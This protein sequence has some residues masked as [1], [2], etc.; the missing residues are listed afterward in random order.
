MP[1]VARSGPRELQ[2]RANDEI[3]DMAAPCQSDWQELTDWSSDR[4]SAANEEDWNRLLVV[5]GRIAASCLHPV[6]VLVG[7]PQFVESLTRFMLTHAQRRRRIASAALLGDAATRAIAQWAL[8]R[9][10]EL[11]PVQWLGTVEP[12]ADHLVGL[13]DRGDLWLALIELA[14]ATLWSDTLRDD[15]DREIWSLLRLVERSR[16][17][18]VVGAQHL[19]SL[20]DALDERVRS[21]DLQRMRD[22]HWAESIA[23]ASAI[24]E[25]IAALSG[26][27]NMRDELY[28][29]VSRW[30]APP[31]AIEAAAIAAKRMRDEHVSEH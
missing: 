28:L 6:E 22:V 20:I 4:L 9:A 10:G 13:P 14:D 3:P 11:P 5:V 26:G 16:L 29:I 31:L 23:C 2:Q 17:I 30:A 21:A 24:A 25:R 27:H 1:I 15:T 18:D 7:H 12:L 8:S 19:R